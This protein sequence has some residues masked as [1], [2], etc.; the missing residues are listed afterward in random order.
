MNL[1]GTTQAARPSL[2]FLNGSEMG[3]MMRSYD[4]QGTPI[5]VPQDWPQPLKTLVGVMLASMHPMFVAWGPERTMLYNDAYAELLVGKHPAALG[6]SFLKVWAEALDDLTPL[7]DQVFAGDPVHMDDLSIRLNR[8]GTLEEAHFAFS[9][10]PVRDETGAVAGLFCAVM[11]TTNRVLA[12]RQRTAATEQLR[13]MFGQAP[14]FIAMLRGPEHVFDLTN[15]AY[16]QLIGHREVVGES[17]R[18][19]LP[20]VEGQGFFEKLD[21][22]FQSGETFAGRAVPVNLQRV[23]DAPIERRFMDF[24]YQPVTDTAG[25]VTGIFVEGSDVTERVLAEA[26]LR[27]SEERSRRIVEGVKD[28]AIFTTDLN[29]IVKDWTSGAESVFG[30]PAD[31]IQ[32]RS[33]ELLFT[34]AD[35]AAGVPARELTTARAQGYASDERWHIRQDGSRFFANGSVRPL[36]GGT[37]DIVGFIKICRDETARRAVEAR[38][39][40]SEEFNRRILASSADCIKVLDLDGN[41]E[42]LSEGGM[43]ALEVDNFDA[44]KGN[45]WPNFWPGEK[46]ADA[47]AAIEK[48]KQG[49]TARFQGL[50]ST[51]KGTPRWWDVIVTPITDEDGHSEKLLSISRDITATKQAEEALRDLNATLESR[52]AARTSERNMLSSILENSD[53]MVLAVGL[54]FTILAINKANVDELERIYG[55]TPKAGDNLL[56][57]LADQPDHQAE[58]RAGWERGLAAEELTFVEEYGDAKRIRPYYEV[59]FRALRNDAGKRI[60]TYQFVTDVT[61]RLREQALLAEAQEALRQSQKL[62]AM[63]QLTGGVSHDFNNLLTPIIGSLDLLQR[64]GVGSE[65][66][67]RL[68]NGAL[69]SAERAKTLVQ[70]LL[71]FARRQP[72]QAEAVDIAAL[73]ESMSD[74]VA[75]TSGPRVRLEMEVAPGLPPAKADANQLEMALLNLAVNARDAMPDG[76]TL[77]ISA[78]TCTMEAGNRLALDPGTYVRLAV[79]DTGIGMDEATLVRAI[80]PFFSTKGVGRGTGL[81]L[82]MVHGLA[83]QLGGSLDIASRLGGGTTVALWLPITTEAVGKPDQVDQAQRPAAAKGAVLLVDDEELV[84]AST[85]DM[86]TELG[87]AVI[88]AGSAEQALQLVDDGLAFDFLVTDHLMPGLTGTQ[89]AHVVRDRFAGKP[90]LVIS[91]Y[92]E[93]EDIATNLPRLTKPFRQIDLATSMAE[94]AAS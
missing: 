5:G 81:G 7:L 33:L 36:H 23:P 13:E 73:V 20:E 85:A 76:G 52:I 53:V 31:E 19:A 39:R 66:E 9:Y 14:G 88:E 43:C 87:Y 29:G 89:L 47:L 86:L 90:V 1:Q 8:R 21:E 78:E 30:W 80:E 92:A 45:S 49:G 40:A 91:G 68:I 84:R 22:V 27:E 51:M 94:L 55:V 32:G 93:L 63:G 17:V 24:V 34:P 77:T 35:R 44:I 41:L 54:D 4:W 25:S 67:R 65:R 69:L 60:G 75:S 50:G 61:E 62:E 42:F 26:E 3:V 28:H 46:H 71:A 2:E 74:L 16:M 15:A 18:K 38:L 79:G 57:L 82:S 48:A 37:G 59:S 58:V 72:L 64:T 10:T 70:R 6:E 11:E 12:E 56:A 83:A